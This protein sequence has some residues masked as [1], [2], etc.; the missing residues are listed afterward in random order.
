MKTLLHLT[1]KHTIS[2]L[3]VAGWLLLA[4]AP[5]QAQDETLID[6]TSLEQLDAIRYDL[7]GDGTPSGNTTKKAAYRAAFGLTGTNNNTCTG[8]CEGYELTTDLDFEDDNS[9]ADGS[10]DLDWIDPD[11]G[12]TAST[13]GWA[14]I[15]DTSNPFEVIFEGNNNTISNIFIDRSST[16][17][18]G[19]FSYA[20]SGAEIRGLGIEGGTV[21][22][23]EYISS[24]VGWN[25]GTIIDCY[26]TEI[27]VTS[28][29]Y[30]GG[31]VGYNT[32]TITAC[33]ATGTV[34]A[35][36]NSAYVGGLVG[37]NN[38][39]TIT[40]C[41]AKVDVETTGGGNARVGGLVGNNPASSTIKACYATGTVTAAGTTPRAGGL[42]GYNTGTITACYA[43]GEVTAGGTNRARGLVG[44]NSGTVNYSYFDSDASNRPATDDNAKTKAEL[45]TP[46]AYGTGTSIY[47]N[48]DVDV[49]NNLSIGVDNGQ[50]AG[51]A[52]D[53]DPWDFGTGSDYPVL[54]VDFDR[55]GTAGVYEFGDQGRPPADIDADN[56]GLIEVSTL[57]QL[58]AIRYDLNG[59]G[60][61]SS[62]GVSDY[63]AAFSLLAGQ[64][65]SCGDGVDITSCIGY[66]LT[67]SLDF[68]DAD[69]DGTADD[70]SIWAEGAV[71]ASI[72]GAVTGG[73]LPIGDNSTTAD[74]S[75]F[76]AIFEGNNNTISNI[77]INRSSTE[78]VGLFG[79]LGP[80]AEVRNLGLVGGSVK[81]SQIIGCLAGISHGT[82]TACYATG[83]A[84]GDTLRY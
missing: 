46:T 65:G 15:G 16:N 56:N 14:P 17:D 61:P 30:P 41:Y 31:L 8:D 4:V 54:K 74:D 13:S 79:G 28:S 80:D 38:G 32:G 60:T 69:G 50:A 67:T 21:T 10:K 78:V 25:T 55:N 45:Q 49:D 19:L 84:R 47:K 7:D 27:D 42:V 9:Y 18:V 33:Y 68:E 5:L 72:S 39:G 73:W 57:E 75:R 37:E 62:S 48:W 29:D 71:G 3:F 36:G 59:D 2:R 34:T 76:T 12:G 77:F 70:K 52:G 43:T 20:G 11:N 26:A 64:V 82:I 66:E 35:A 53:D 1:Q 40:A 22:G 58:N 63:E 51:D 6:I 24:L 81:G 83:N 44:N 23:S